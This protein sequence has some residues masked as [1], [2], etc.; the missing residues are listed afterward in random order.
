MKI[1]DLI[2]IDGDSGVIL[3]YNSSQNAWEVMLGN[4]KIEFVVDSCELSEEELEMVRGGMSDE[5]FRVW[6]GEVLSETR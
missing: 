4:G 5:T 1:G 2:E 6:H 3:N